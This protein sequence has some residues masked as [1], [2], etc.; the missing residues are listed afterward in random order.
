MFGR[1]TAFADELIAVAEAHPGLGGFNLDLECASTAEDGVAYAGFL[2]S[3][4]AR[5]KAHQPD[6]RFTADVSCEAGAGW[7]PMISNCSLLAASGADRIMD[8]RTYNAPDA[9][10]WYW[11]DLLPALAADP[12]RSRVAVGL[13]C[14]NDSRTDGTWNLT[15]ESAEQR[16]CMLMNESVNEIDMFILSPEKGFPLPFWIPQL[17]RFVAGGGCDA[18][19]P[20]KTVCPT[21]AWAPGGGAG[22]CESSERRGPNVTCS[23]ACAK[24][25]C[26]KANMAWRPENFSSHP[27]ECCHEHRHS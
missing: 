17:E 11:S 26:A 4:T 1:A 25:E 20:A 21:P 12:S 5:L 15:P 13:G 2:S 6:L 18:Q 3:V 16:V 10:S 23:I 19:F 7:S 14:W 9:A 24:A 22:C 8:M 27:Y